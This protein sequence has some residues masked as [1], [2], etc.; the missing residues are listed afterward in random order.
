MYEGPERRNARR[1]PTRAWVV[2]HVGGQDR[3]GLALDVS[4]GGLFVHTSATVR[5]GNRLQLAIALPDKE[6]PSLK[7]VA[8]VLWW[9]ESRNGFG[10]RFV[11]LSAA[12]FSTIR[13]FVASVVSPSK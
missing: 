4:E 7:A 1:V 9:D 12:G 2:L 10:L 13:T 5:P 11:E 8:E 3:A 6:S